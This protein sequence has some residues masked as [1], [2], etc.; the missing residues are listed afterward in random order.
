MS[1]EIILLLLFLFGCFH[2]YFS[3]LIALTSASST[4]LTRSGESGHFFFVPDIRGKV[5]SLSPLVMFAVCVSYVAFTVWRWFPI[6]ILCRF[7][8]W[9]MLNLVTCIFWI[10]I[11]MCFFPLILLMWWIITLINFRIL[12]YPC[13]AGIN[14]TLAW[15]IILLICYWIVFA[16]ILLRIST[17]V[18]IRDID[19]QFSSLEMS[20][21]GFGV[22]VMLVS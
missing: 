9:K 4:I 14:L 5:F 2:P 3:F 11:I 18:F 17:L 12:N 22:R 6:S 16:S 1:V 10:K 19:L 15:Y 7:L 20:F 13:T 8:S 21:F